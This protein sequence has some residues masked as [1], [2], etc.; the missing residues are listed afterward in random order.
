MET[1]SGFEEIRIKK[2]ILFPYF[3]KIILI[4]ILFAIFFI[5]TITSIIY[6]GIILIDL[7]IKHWIYLLGGLA[8]ILFLIFFIKRRKKKTKNEYS[9]K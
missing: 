2:K 9:I 6:F 3:I 1:I 5:T 7:I 8:I 4:G